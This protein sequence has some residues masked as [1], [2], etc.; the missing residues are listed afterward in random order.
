MANKTR[1]L[2]RLRYIQQHSDEQ[3]ALTT[4]E[5]RNALLENGYNTTVPTLRDDIETLMASGFDISVSEGSG[6][7]TTYRYVDR[8]W[9][10]PELQIL[11]DA[12]SSS[13]F[14]TTEKSK[15]LIRSF[16]GSC[17]SVRYGDSGT[18][19]LGILLLK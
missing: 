5:L 18:K 15:E 12:V 14:L 4:A 10:T 9:T 6:V 8:E 13:L 2:F 16:V 11:I 3:H 19:H 7:T 1:V 17:Q